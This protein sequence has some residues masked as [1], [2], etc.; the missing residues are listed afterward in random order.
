MFIC[1]IRWTV[2][3]ILCDCVFFFL[4]PFFQIY[5]NDII[6]VHACIKDDERTMFKSKI[7]DLS[8]RP[9]VRPSV[10]PGIWSNQTTQT[11]SSNIDQSNFEVGG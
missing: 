5:L 7:N 11:W 8:V 3:F 4:L 2:L 6:K 10:S 9:S 1:L